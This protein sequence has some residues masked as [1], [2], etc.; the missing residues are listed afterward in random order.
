MRQTPLPWAHGGLKQSVLRG[1]FAQPSTRPPLALPWGSRRRTEM[2]SGLYVF[3]A[4]IDFGDLN[5][6]PRK[7]YLQKQSII[8]CWSVLFLRELFFIASCSQ[9]LEFE[10]RRPVVFPVHQDLTHCG[11]FLTGDSFSALLARCVSAVYELHFNWR[12]FFLALLA[13]CVVECVRGNAILD[14]STGNSYMVTCSKTASP[15]AIFQWCATSH[16]LTPWGYKMHNSDLFYSIRISTL[17]ALLLMNANPRSLYLCLCSH[18]DFNTHTCWPSY[19][20]IMKETKMTKSIEI[21][22]AIE[23]LAELEW[24]TVELRGRK[25]YYKITQ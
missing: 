5:P 3:L 12:R 20:T 8:H 22:E 9:K 16:P 10:I 4:Q 23:S 1:A 18:A 15:D 2:S 13:R 7:R 14:G 17:R 6:H 24:I 21:T 19:S 25:N 11:Y